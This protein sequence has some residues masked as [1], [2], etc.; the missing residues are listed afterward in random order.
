MNLLYLFRFNS[1][2]NKSG[3]TPRMR[4]LLGG[5]LGSSL[6]TSGLLLVLFG[7]AILVA[8]ELLAYIVAT[9]LIMGGVSMLTAGLTM[10]RAGKKVERMFIDAR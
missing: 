6:I 3:Y 5:M 1:I 8:P 4:F 10:R 2:R 9:A 7:I